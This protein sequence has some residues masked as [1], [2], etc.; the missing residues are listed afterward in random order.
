ML[1]N[2]K[3]AWAHS[4][5]LHQ[6]RPTWLCYCFQKAKRLADS[7]GIWGKFRIAYI[8][9]NWLSP[10]SGCYWEHWITMLLCEW[11]QNNGHSI[12]MAALTNWLW[13]SQLTSL[14][15]GFLLHSRRIMI[16]LISFRLW[17]W[18]NEIIHV[19]KTLE[20]ALAPTNLSIS[21]V[22]NDCFFTHLYLLPS[23]DWLY[24]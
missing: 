6:I 12:Q 22:Y 10:E 17:W 20:W 18:W 14:C 3:K 4:Q 21:I 9:A 16:A 2:I 8:G 15:L 23:M 19:N 13:N 1:R 24:F 7:I 5:D 11:I